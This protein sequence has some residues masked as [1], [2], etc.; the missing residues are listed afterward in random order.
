MLFRE[1]G[2]K[3]DVLRR[4]GCEERKDGGCGKDRK[5]S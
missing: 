1:G 2:E 4:K 5:K 3:E